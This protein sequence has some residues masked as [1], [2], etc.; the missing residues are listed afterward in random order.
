MA[1][2]PEDGTKMVCVNDGISFAEYKCPKCD[3]VWQYDAEQGCYR[4][5]QPEEQPP[6]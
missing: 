1:Y 2:C 6:K 3:T 4:V 5:I